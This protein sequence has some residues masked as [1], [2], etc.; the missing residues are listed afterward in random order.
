MKKIVDITGKSLERI[1]EILND[2][3]DWMVITS[4]TTKYAHAHTSSGFGRNV[5]WT[6]PPKE[7]SFLIFE[8]KHEPYDFK[9]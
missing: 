8:K 7:Y 5:M 4:G 9:I 3:P 6:D 1:Q 2:N